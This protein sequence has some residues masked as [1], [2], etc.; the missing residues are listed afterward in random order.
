VSTAKYFAPRL[1]AAFTRMHPHLELRLNVG[2]RGVV[3]EALRD[4]TVDLTITGRP[5]EDIDVE[6]TAFGKH[7][8]VVIAPADHAMA[9][10]RA[11][12]REALAGQRFLIREPGSGTRAAFEA[13]FGSLGAGL[14][15][16][17]EIA[18]NETIKQA[19][20]AGLGIALI[21]G[22]TVAAEIADGRL[23]AL[24]IVG[25]PVMRDWYAVRRSDRTLSNA[26]AAFFTFL[27]ESGAEFLP[28][29][30]LFKASAAA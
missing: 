30:M 9:K 14:T 13:T 16:G 19:V 22:H 12:P 21:S 17:M 23:V 26:A 5:P 8:L 15:T 24:D 1:M 10:R 20:I 7:P 4:Y 11:I 6:A 25:L 18:S 27:R 2:N 29:P 3:F 28:P